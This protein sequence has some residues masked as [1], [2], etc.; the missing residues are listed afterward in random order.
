MFG[1]RFARVCTREWPEARH[2]WLGY[3]MVGLAGGN[4]AL[5]WFLIGFGLG[6]LGGTIAFLVGTIGFAR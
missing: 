1:P 4:I 6:F 2:A 5:F 3:V